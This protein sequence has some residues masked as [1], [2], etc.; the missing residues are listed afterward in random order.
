MYMDSDRCLILH[1]L[2]V[3]LKVNTVQWKRIDNLLFSLFCCVRLTFSSPFESCNEMFWVAMKLWS[4]KVSLRT[5]MHVDELTMFYHD[6][7]MNTILQGIE[8]VSL[9]IICVYIRVDHTRVC[10]AL[11]LFML[12]VDLEEFIDFFGVVV[13]QGSES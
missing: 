11:Q 5:A 8:T 9:Q 2:S 13:P 4:I 6:I 7:A 1:V 3:K 12:K 10:L